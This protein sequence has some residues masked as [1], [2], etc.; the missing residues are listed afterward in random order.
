[1]NRKVQNFLWYF[2]PVGIVISKWLRGPS[3]YNN[4][5][6]YKNVFW[7][8]LHQ[9][10]LYLFYPTEYFDH[11][12]YGPLFAL[13]IAPFA[14]LP[15]VFGLIAWILV[16]MFVLQKGLSYFWTDKPPFL[17]FVLVLI[18]AT[19][20]CHNTQFNIM[21]AGGLLWSFGLI[22]K[23]YDWVSSLIIVILILTKIYGV[24]GLILVFFTH[25]PWKFVYAT[26][27]W[28]IVLLIFPS[29]ISSPQFVFQS[30]VDWY[31][32]IVHKNDLNQLSHMSNGM[33]DISAMGLIKRI[34]GNFDLSNSWFLIPAML[35]TLLPLSRFKELKNS[36]FQLDYFAQVMIGLVIFSSSSESSTY[37]IAIAGMAVWLFNKY[38]Q[39][40]YVWLIVFVGILTVLS[41][42]DLFPPSIRKDVFVKYALKALPCLATWLQITYQL[43]V[44]K[45]DN[46]S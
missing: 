46:E 22:K 32:T 23:G 12:L 5:L 28:T 2:I 38:T 35:L 36:V 34:S 17:L 43:L 15:D 24:V 29:V 42:T 31:N 45:Y 10:N 13:I 37:I 3:T 6:I 11:N 14:L 19:T 4:F 1:M 27:I 20:A 40:P 44:K 16:S 33:Q 41:P 21:M 39:K 25:K 26:A 18:E 8:T 9:K 30:Y 7:H